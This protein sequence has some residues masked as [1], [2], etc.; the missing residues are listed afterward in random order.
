MKFYRVGGCVR[1]ALL[2]ED[3]QRRGELDAALE[4]DRDW[5]V[6]GGTP[7]EMTARGF[8]PVGRD[9]PVF[10]HPQTHEEYALARTERKTAPG[11]KGFIFH[12]AP[13]VTLEEDLA[14]RDLTINA[15]ALDEDGRLID[16][17]NGARDLRAGILRHV[18][19]AFIE[20]PVRILRLARFAARFPEF[21]IA[22]QTAELVKQ[23]V[24]NGEADALVPERVMQ[25]LSRG[26]MERKPSRML[27]A[28]AASGLIG[29]LYSELED[30]GPAGAAL[31]RAAAR[32]LVLP[33]RFAV[34][35]SACRSPRTVA[36]LIGKLRASQESAQLARLLV[37]L[38]DALAQ[39]ESS[40]SIVDTLERAD[41][42]RRPERFEL[43]LQ[44]FETAYEKPADR[45]RD[46]L[47]AAADV[48][49]G[50][51]ASLHRN[52]PTEIPRA[53][54]QARIVAVSRALHGDEQRDD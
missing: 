34:L 17:H 38:R 53:V 30:L 31:D 14:R 48:D 49:A 21:R 19:P 6:V 36:D 40:A 32:G 13:D 43:L 29:R 50:A 46:A 10:L 20:D 28:L 2:G 39:S 25:E 24:A 18:G 42:F 54:R 22:P 1:D 3:R 37:E 12:A 45:F 27:D 26:L 44:T 16:P 41:A 9:F 4:T 8:R 11:Y 7:D 5:V 15:M 51:L 52:D 35:A 23:M 33:A 47:H